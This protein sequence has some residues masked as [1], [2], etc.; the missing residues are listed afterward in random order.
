MNLPRFPRR[1]SDGLIRP[2]LLTAALAAGLGSLGAADTEA[3]AISS[4]AATFYVR[5][6]DEAGKTV[7]ETYIFHE[8]NFWGGST[9]DPSQTKLNFATLTK[10]LATNL[11]KQSYYP[12]REVAT[13]NILIRVDWGTTLTYEDPRGKQFLTEQLN[14]ELAA[15][16]SA[17][18]ESGMADTGGINQA[19]S[20]GQN[21]TMSQD[22]F[23]ARNAAL[24]GYDRALGKEMRKMMPTPEE[25][26]MATEL[27]EERYF[28]I[29]MAYDYQFMRKEKKPKLLWVT[30][31]SLR[32]PGNNFTDAMP[33]LALAG[34]DVYGRQLNGLVRVKVPVQSGTV[35]LH[36]L[37]VIG[38]EKTPKPADQPAK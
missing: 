24:L 27:N 3:V 7:P 18:T 1:F 21:T 6:K 34:A 36:D 11:A 25:L 8:G 29:L 5:G 20:E 26:T 13:A 15:V 10:Y 22:A 4:T 30:R 2:F 32:S 38:E 9:A 28:V 37:Q 31:L 17:V 12:T 14:R 16:N 33:T 35:K 23:I 19:L